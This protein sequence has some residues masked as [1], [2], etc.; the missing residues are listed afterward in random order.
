MINSFISKGFSSTSSIGIKSS[1]QANSLDSPTTSKSL[2]ES[3]SSDELDDGIGAS[4]SNSMP[5]VFN[6]QLPIIKRKRNS[7]SGY[8]SSSNECG[9]SLTETTGPVTAMEMMK[10]AYNL[11]SH[12]QQLDRDLSKQEKPV[13]VNLL[14]ERILEL[15]MSMAMKNFLLYHRQI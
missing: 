12:V 8:V 13:K 3:E 4:W 15:P 2:A 7:S 9:S 11:K 6:G 14:R 1:D 5:R 10:K